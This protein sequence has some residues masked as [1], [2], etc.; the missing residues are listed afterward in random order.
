M[1]FSFARF[2]LQA[3]RVLSAK[4]LLAPCVRKGRRMLFFG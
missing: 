3:A 1:M 4:F 2:A